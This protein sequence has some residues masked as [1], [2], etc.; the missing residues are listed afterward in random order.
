MGPVRLAGLMLELGGSRAKHWLV[1]ALADDL[2]FDPRF[3]GALLRWRNASSAWR[4]AVF[5]RR[6][7]PRARS[8]T[9]THRSRDEPHTIVIPLVKVRVCEI[10]V[11]AKQHILQPADDTARSR[12]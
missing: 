4:A 10:R 12:D 9:A 8:S 1:P 7:P 5:F 6:R 11:A 2:L 3:A